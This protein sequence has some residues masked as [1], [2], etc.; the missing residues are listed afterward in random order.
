MNETSVESAFGSSLSEVVELPFSIPISSTPSL[1]AELPRLSPIRREDRCKIKWIACGAELGRRSFEMMTLPVSMLQRTSHH[2]GRSAKAGLHTPAMNPG[3][4]RGRKEGVRF[5]FLRSIAWNTVHVLQVVQIG[6]VRIGE[7]AV[8]DAMQYASASASES[9]SSEDEFGYP[10]GG[11]TVSEKDDSL[12]RQDGV[13]EDDDGRGL[14]SGGVEM[15][16]MW[17]GSER[18]WTGEGLHELDE[19][20]LRVEKARSEPHRVSF[21]VARERERSTHIANLGRER[22]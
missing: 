15:R 2:E 12:S 18:S 10:S 9:T 20:V 8:F 14:C 22:R 13:Q 7:C 16:V 6:Q 19:R 21:D 5:V 3:L 11:L 17:T 4:R 1:P